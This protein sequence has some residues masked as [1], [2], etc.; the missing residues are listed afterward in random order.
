MYES[1]LQ[2]LRASLPEFLGALM[3]TL[4]SAAVGWSVKRTR[5]RRGAR[6]AANAAPPVCGPVV[7]SSRRRVRPGGGDGRTRSRRCRASG[8][9]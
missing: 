1:L 4:V 2:M 6:R 7:W 8:P 5:D 3:A 9:R